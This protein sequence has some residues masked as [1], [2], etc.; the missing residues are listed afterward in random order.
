[1]SNF[2]EMDI[3]AQA[4]LVTEVGNVLKNN[5]L[6]DVKVQIYREE[7]CQLTGENV[8]GRTMLKVEK[9]LPATA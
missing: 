7:V 5:N 6:G 1:M 8:M 2:S 3:D 9:Q 4:N